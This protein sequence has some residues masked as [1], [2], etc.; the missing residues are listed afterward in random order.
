[1]LLFEVNSVAHAITLILELIYSG[2]CARCAFLTHMKSNSYSQLALAT[3]TLQGEWSGLKLLMI[4]LQ[5][6]QSKFELLSPANYS[7]F[8][9]FIS[10]TLLIKAPCIA[11]LEGS[12]LQTEL[13]GEIYNLSIGPTNWCLISFASEA[14]KMMRR[15]FYQSLLQSDSRQPS[16]SP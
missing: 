9:A 13:L 7:A 15:R 6:P 10:G 4:G 2:V 12:P 8:L 11:F 5:N 14:S 3:N 1:M 16:L